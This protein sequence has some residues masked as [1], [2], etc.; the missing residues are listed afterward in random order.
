MKP[1]AIVVIDMLH[2]FL[3]G[4]L[5][6]ERALAIIPD[7]QKLLNFAREREILIVYVCDSHSPEDEEFKKWPPHAIKGTKGAEIIPELKPKE[8]DIVI[9][10]TRYSGFYNTD[11]DTKLKEFGVKTLILT[12]ILT[13]ICVQHTAAD[14]FFRNYKLIVPKET[15]ETLSQERKEYSLRYM[16]DIYGAK[17]LSVNEW[18]EG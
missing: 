8:G 16:S 5:K 17:I 1:I 11:L 3:Y 6:C 2:D 4:N 12:G 13:D 7:L 15:T 14:A 18:L 9:E 10:K